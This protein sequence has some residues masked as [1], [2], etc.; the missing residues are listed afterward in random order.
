MN[1]VGPVGKYEIINKTVTGKVIYIDSFG[2]IIT[3]ID[4]DSFRQVLNYD[5]KIMLFIGDKRLEMPFCKSYNFVKKGEFL[6]TIGSSNLLEISINQGNAEKELKIK[7]D[8]DLKI[9]LD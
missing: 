1:S 5:K 6:T 2:N 9:L 7:P 8:E 3:N 4:G